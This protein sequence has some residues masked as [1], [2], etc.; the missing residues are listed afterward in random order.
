MTSHDTHLASHDHYLPSHDHDHYCQLQIAE[1]ILSLCLRELFEFHLMQ[2]D[3]NWSNFFYNEEDKKV[4]Y[5]S[6]IV[7]RP[8]PN[9]R[10][11]SLVTFSRSLE[12]DYFLGRVFHTSY[13]DGMITF[14]HPAI[15]SW[16]WCYSKLLQVLHR[17][18][19]S[20]TYTCRVFEDMA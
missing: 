11:D 20:G 1:R 12:L 10:G 3:P 13:R 2:T 17:W 14:S 19:H 9:P 4:S 18:L 6:H 15:S 16:F 8:Y 7:S 5:T